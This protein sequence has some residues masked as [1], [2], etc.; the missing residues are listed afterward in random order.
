[1]KYV[2]TLSLAL[3]TIVASAHSGRTNK[4]GCHHDRKHGGYHCHNSK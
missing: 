2:I 3:L 1:M 4:N